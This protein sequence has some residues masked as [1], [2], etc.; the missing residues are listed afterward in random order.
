VFASALVVEAAENPPA[1]DWLAPAVMGGVIAVMLT[2]VGWK[3]VTHAL[4]AVHE[5]AHALFTSTSGGKVLGVTIGR[6][7]GGATG[8]QGIGWLGRFFT[9]MAGYL[10]PSMFGLAGAFLLIHGHTVP[11]LWLSLGFLAILLLQI[12]N[13]FGAFV[14]VVTGGLLYLVVRYTAGMVQACL[15]FAWIWLLLIGGFGDVIAL[16]R[17]RGQAKQAGRKD[18]SSDAHALRTLTFLPA[19]MW[20]GMLWLLTLVGLIFGAGLLLGLVTTG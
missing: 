9:A 14:V 1:R 15:A 10:G 20:V 16:A 17:L 19:S 3:V 8:F 4:T 11:V 5:G 12:R 6:D 18:D 13:P 7:G 2:V